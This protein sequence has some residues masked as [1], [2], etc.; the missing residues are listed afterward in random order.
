MARVAVDKP[1][2]ALARGNRQGPLKN[3][4]KCLQVFGK[5]RPLAF[6]PIPLSGY[7]GWESQLRMGYY[8]DA[9]ATALHK[10]QFLFFTRP[11]VCKP[12]FG[13]SEQ[14]AQKSMVLV[15]ALQGR[16]KA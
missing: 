6:T 2:A 16:W 10:A 1:P 11:T 14:M 15:R 8:G 12:S 3:R 7:Q 13:D 9:R 5:P 4:W